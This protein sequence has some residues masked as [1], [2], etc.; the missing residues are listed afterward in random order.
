MHRFSGCR[1]KVPASKGNEASLLTRVCESGMSKSDLSFGQST[2]DNSQTQYRF[3]PVIL[4]KRTQTC[5]FGL[6]HP[7]GGT[8]PRYTIDFDPSRGEAEYQFSLKEVKIR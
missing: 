2:G 1:F 6:D 8:R 3:W 4:S 7:A 5:A